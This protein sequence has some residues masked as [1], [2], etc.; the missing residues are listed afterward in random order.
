MI[1]PLEEQFS[2]DKCDEIKNLITKFSELPFKGGACRYL[3]LEV[4]GCL[5]AGLLLAAVSVASILLETS[6]RELLIFSRLQTVGPK[7]NHQTDT[8]LLLD[9][10]EK[11]IEDGP[12]RLNF[13]DIV[14]EL[15]SDVLNSGDAKN[16]KKFF[17]DVRNPIHHGITRRFIAKVRSE[18][19][20][21]SNPLSI[22]LSDTY[23]MFRL[24]RLDEVIEENTTKHLRFIVDLI[25]K[26]T[27]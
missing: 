1:R 15:S 24:H 9:K 23:R 14:D 26:Y 12:P 11:E 6:F 4:I 22:I 27:I 16:A 20:D 7:T 2:P 25:Q 19:V 8:S 3:V 17:K 5:E 13:E 18:K 10:L 21:M